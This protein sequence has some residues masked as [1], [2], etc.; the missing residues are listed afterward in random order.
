MA[1]RLGALG[2][3]V[4]LHAHTSSPQAFDLASRLQT[5]GI[6]A[7][8]IEGDLSRPEEAAALVDRA[9]KAIGKNLDFLINNAAT[10]TPASMQTVEWASVGRDMAINAWAPF[11][12]TRAFHAQAKRPGAVVNLLDTR[13]ED[14]DWEH[15]G[16]QLSKKVL[17]E[18]TRLQAVEY[19]PKLRVNGVAPGPILPPEGDAE[20]MLDRVSKHLP[21]RKSPSPDDVADAVLYLLGARGVTG[22]VLHVDGGRHLGRA[23]Y[24]A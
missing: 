19:A 5:R 18:M 8:A 16:Y 20:A 23:V 7:T 10:Y 2:C 3:N 1:Q 22:E 13:I 4:V 11:A 9:R 21:L 24:D 12:L 14:Y 15:V 6:E 17:A